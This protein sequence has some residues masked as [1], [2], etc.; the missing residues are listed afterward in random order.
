MSTWKPSARLFAVTILALA[1]ALLLSCSSKEKA[2]TGGSPTAQGSPT[3]EG[4]PSAEASPTPELTPVLSPAPPRVP[5]TSNVFGNPGFEDGRDPWFSLKAP[6]FELANVAHSGQNSAHLMMRDGPETAGAKVYYLV[7]EVNPTEFPE[8]ISGYY[9]VDNWVK[10]TPKQYLQFVAIVFGAENRPP[11]F[12]NH[13]IRY[14]LAGISEDPFKINNAKFVYLSKDEPVQGE[15]VPFKV[16]VKQDF[17]DLWG[18][19]PVNYERI[20]LLFEVR[21]DDKIPNIG[22]PEAD[23]YYDDLYFGPA[24]GASV[25]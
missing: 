25:P 19:V 13:Q 20:R 10:G 18:A 24:E 22:A 15:W 17:Q 12:P 4:S 23:V 16:N 11:E 14:L 7:Q 6:D 1:T 3:A 21:F 8:V 2:G 9:R 5:A